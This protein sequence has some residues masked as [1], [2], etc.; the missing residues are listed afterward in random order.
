MPSSFSRALCMASSSLLMRGSGSGCFVELLLLSKTKGTLTVRG[1][2]LPLLLKVFGRCP[3]FGGAAFCLAGGLLSLWSLC[4]TFTGLPLEP[5]TVLTPNFGVAS[6]TTRCDL[7]SSCCFRVLEVLIKLRPGVGH[8]PK[9]ESRQSRGTSCQGVGEPLGSIPPYEQ[10]ACGL[11]GDS[12]RRV[13]KTFRLRMSLAGSCADASSD[14]ASRDCVCSES[15]NA[16]A[17]AYF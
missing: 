12:V 10:D 17:Q 4:G 11:R 1:A 15:L 3:G 9:L 2:L 5:N 6:V 7:L 13:V 8:L 14:E 16:L